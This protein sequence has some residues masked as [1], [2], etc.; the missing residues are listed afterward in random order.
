MLK[1][2]SVIESALLSACSTSV[3]HANFKEFN[4]HVKLPVHYT[5]SRCE[6]IYNQ[7]WAFEGL[8]KC[9]HASMDDQERAVL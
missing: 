7:I 4:H 1:R 3:F 2:C 5:R 9:L 6:I 8:A